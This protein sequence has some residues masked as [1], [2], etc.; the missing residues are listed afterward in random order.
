MHFTS[1]TSAGL[2]LAPSAFG[3]NLIASHYTGK[4]YSLSYTASGS[5]G[6]LAITGSVS[7]CGNMPSWLQLD[8]ASGTLLCT[9]ES[10]N[11]GALST[12]VVAN[13]GAVTLNGSARTS[14]GDVHGSF[15]GGSDGKGFA[16]L[17][18]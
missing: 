6:K 16:V 15:Y 17:A 14:G 11:S 18:E 4:L 13:S 12:F 2:A 7:G 5:T 8:S 9:D 1:T 3:A 10:S